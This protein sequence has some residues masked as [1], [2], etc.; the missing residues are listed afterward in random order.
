MH[1]A[2][3]VDLCSPDTRPPIGQLPAVLAEK[4]GSHFE[5]SVTHWKPDQRPMNFADSCLAVIT[6]CCRR[7]PRCWTNSAVQYRPVVHRSVSFPLFRNSW[8]IYISQP[9]N[10]RWKKC[11]NRTHCNVSTV[12]GEQQHCG[13]STQWSLTHDVQLCA[14]CSVDTVLLVIMG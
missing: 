4:S 10:R 6:P 14:V 11:N 3:V 12:W 2:V 7:R 8:R 1:T 5:T 9:G 13:E